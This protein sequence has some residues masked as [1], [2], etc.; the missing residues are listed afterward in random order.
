MPKTILFSKKSVE[1]LPVP[2]KSRDV[3]MD[4]RNKYLW[5]R[6]TKTGHR[7]FYYVRWIDG[8]PQWLRIGTFPETTVSQ[9]RAACDILNGKI[10]AG[11][12][13]AEEKLKRRQAKTFGDLFEIYFEMHSKPHKKSA[14]FDEMCFRNHLPDLN[15][16]PLR[17]ITPETI[18]R[19]HK[20]IGERSGRIMSNR[21]FRV[22]RAVFNFAINQRIIEG[23]N[24][25]NGI[26]QFREQS[27]E[28]FMNADEVRRFFNALE[29][30]P[31]PDMKDFFTL[32]LFIAVRRGNLQSMKWRDVDLDRG[33]WIIQN[34]E[35]KSGDMM[36]VILAP[37]SVEILRQRYEKQGTGSM[38]VFPS[39]RNDSRFGHL[40]DP[41][42]AWKR[43]CERA[44]LVDLHM[45]DLRRTR[46][47][48]QAAC[49][50]SLL[51]IG[52]SLGHKSQAA[53]A[54]YARLDLDPIRASV[55][56]AVKA[57]IQAGNS[58]QKG[59]ED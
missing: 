12:N 50:S 2:M 55:G 17:G 34:E 28:R 4:E 44:G 3:Y 20:Q 48:F 8:K 13:P 45:H 56:A 22:V 57:M 6:I 31:D 21:V 27:R 25:C 15:A 29:T 16:R 59:D 10:A 30:E 42:R 58:Q 24:P 14:W 1:A 53:T 52:K 51:I 43:F 39:R 5:L 38:F 49:G 11:F 54:I 26:K 35:S 41:K 46:G 40:V 7:S 37:E 33:L 47:S 36:R 18:S 32:L 19:L 23:P 9:A